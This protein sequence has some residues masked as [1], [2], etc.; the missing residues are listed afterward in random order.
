M[1]RRIVLD[2]EARLSPPPAGGSGGRGRFRLES[3]RHAVPAV[4]DGTV[5]EIRHGTAPLLEGVFE[6]D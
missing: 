6:A 5:V 2:F 3:G 1:V 4:A